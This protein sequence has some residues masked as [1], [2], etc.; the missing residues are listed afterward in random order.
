MAE[1]EKMLVR[2]VIGEDRLVDTIKLMAS[3]GGRLVGAEPFETKA[4]PAPGTG[5]DAPER[6]PG[7]GK[8]RILS[9]IASKRGEQVSRA[10]IILDFIGAGGAESSAGFFLN[11]LKKEGLVI[12]PERGFYA[13]VRPTAIPGDNKSMQPFIENHGGGSNN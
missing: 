5:P 3:M 7:A 9:F 6:K 2:F 12:N 8:Q 4:K 10:D 13:W 1:N 11:E